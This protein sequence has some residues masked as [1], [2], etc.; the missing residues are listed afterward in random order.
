MNSKM[1]HSH[2]NEPQQS[3]KNVIT[4]KCQKKMSTTRA[5]YAWSVARIIKIIIINN[6]LQTI[7]Y[8]CA[9]CKLYAHDHLYMHLTACGWTQH[10][11]CEG[12]RSISESLLPLRRKSAQKKIRLL[13]LR[14]QILI[15]EIARRSWLHWRRRYDGSTVDRR[16]SHVCN[17]DECVNENPLTRQ[18]TMAYIVLINKAILIELWHSMWLRCRWKSLQQ[19]HCIKWIRPDCCFQTECLLRIHFN[20]DMSIELCLVKA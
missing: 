10:C 3:E 17:F 13:A 1:S 19:I 18:Q 7:Y 15:E 4:N 14:K 11:I 6:L 9:S 12:T 16:R 20:R 8:W 5:A 2:L